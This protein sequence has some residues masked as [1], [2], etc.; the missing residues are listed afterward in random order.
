MR[1]PL[2]DN[3]EYFGPY[4]SSA[5]VKKALKYLRRV[6]PFDWRRPVAG[7]KRASL[8]Y[9]IGLSPGI[10]QGKTSIEEYRANLRRLSR[11]LSG[12]R[13]ALK[14]E[15]EK[16]MKRAAKSQQ[17]EEAAV[18]RNRL[19]ALD[20][21]QKQIVFSDREFMDLSK[22]QGLFE[23]T[24]LLS[25]SQVPRRIEG[26]DISH[27]SGTDTVASMVVF[28]NGIP[29]KSAYRKFKMRIPGNDDFAH[30]NEALTRRTSE[31]NRKAWGL[32][33]IFL[34]D[35]GK[36]Q[37]AAAQKALADADILLPAIGL[38]KQEE[39]IVIAKAWESTVLDMSYAKK[40]R[41]TVQESDDFLLV[42]VPHDSHIVKLLQRIRDES[43]RFAVSYH[44]TLKVK[45]Q[46]SSLLDTIPTIGP[47][48]K[49]KLLRTFGSIKGIEQAR[50]IELQKLIGEKKATILRQYLRA[51]RKQH[52]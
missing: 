20:G 18:L 12:E 15:L 39:Q 29:D 19:R 21:L 30:M 35:G 6:F 31:K 2:D 43:H 24:Q 36:G 28:V 8:D 25:L 50:D 14:R 1:R 52:D 10:E 41:A 44:S 23:L 7:Q 5:V 46:R 42:N 16:D 33:S 3:A 17:F 45:R 32:P 40:L 4:Y 37:L 13:V 11:Y 22:D 9:H 38:A 48:T 47:S 51:E 34:I 26:F 27:M 49:K